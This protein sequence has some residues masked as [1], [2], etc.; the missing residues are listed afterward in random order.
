MTYN[1]NKN[2]LENTSASLDCIG[3]SESCSAINSRVATVHEN[4]TSQP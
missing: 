4:L 3:I 2:I 1:L